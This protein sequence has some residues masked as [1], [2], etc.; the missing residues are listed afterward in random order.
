MVVSHQ[1]LQHRQV[2]PGFRQG[3]AQCY[4]YLIL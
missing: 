2:H 1:R 3:G 4:L